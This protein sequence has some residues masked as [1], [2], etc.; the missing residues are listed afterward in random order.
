MATR[1]YPL[2]RRHRAG[3]VRKPG[4]QV[5][6]S[7]A[8]AVRAAV[9]EGLAESQNALVER[10]LLRFLAEERRALLYAAYEEAARDPEFV[11]D[12]EA[13]SA[14]FEPTAGDGLRD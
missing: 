10:A 13:V 7:L 6:V 8:D 11:A 9:E 12:M 5:S 2:R 14:A 4:W 1:A 3:P